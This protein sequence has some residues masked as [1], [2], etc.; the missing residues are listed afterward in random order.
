MAAR[1]A[2]FVVFEQFRKLVRQRAAQF[3]GIDDGHG[4]AI[5]AGDVVADADG[6]QFH[7]RPVLDVV[8]DLAQ[9][10]L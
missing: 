10:A 2:H 7:R 6:D 3:L 1:C 9:V 4:P 8:D 5:I